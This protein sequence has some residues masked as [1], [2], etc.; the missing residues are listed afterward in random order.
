MV[1]E[2]GATHELARF[3]SRVKGIL[4]RLWEGGTFTY[5]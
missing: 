3:A 4:E 1:G 5:G 2:I